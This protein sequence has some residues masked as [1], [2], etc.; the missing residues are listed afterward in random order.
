MDAKP[1]SVKTAIIFHQMSEQSRG[2]KWRGFVL[3]CVKHLKRPV[4]TE[5]AITGVA[6]Q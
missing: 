6:K 1:K 2:L 5:A 3:N 4:K